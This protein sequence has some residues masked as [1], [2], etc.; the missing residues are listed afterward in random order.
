[1]IDII[2]PHGGISL[3]DN[4]LS[5]E[6]LIG[7]SK[8]ASNYLKIHISPRETRD[9][10][11]L[12]IGA[13]SPLDGFAGYEDWKS[14]CND[15]KLA[16]K[17]NVLWPIPITLSVS[18]NLADRIKIGEEIAL[19]SDEF[20]ET[21][22]TMKVE[23]KYPV[24]KEFE[25]KHVYKTT[26]IEHPGVKSVM[27][28]GEINLAGRIKLL[29]E[30]VYSLEFPELYQ[31]PA[32]SRRKFEELGWK[33]IAAF[34]VRNPMHRSH[35]HIVKIALEFVDGLYIHQ[36]TGK[37]KPGEIPTDVRIRCINALIKNYFVKDSVIQGG[38]PLDMRYAGPR[39]AIL[40]A[41]MRQNY[42]CSHFVIG[43]DY[44]GFGNYYGPF[45]SQD[46]FDELWDG[47][48][49][50][51]PLKIDWTFWCYECGNMASM[52]TCP[53][54]KESKLLL[55]GTLLRKKL[56]EGMNIPG[57]YSRKEVID[58]LSEYYSGMELPP[59]EPELLPEN[60]WNIW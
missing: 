31:N 8:K 35:E 12:G 10:I 13:F 55:S 24:N 30:G 46:I 40:H 51:Q 57:E 56:T 43:R 16:G 11:M 18:K 45:E 17:N 3:V 49:D 52:K 4:L 50:C 23:E 48:L 25:C 60:D 9:L 22:A 5:G 29:S 54:S 34:Q 36:L 42:G 26:D 38:Y 41:I 28:Q 58:I 7:E 44:A 53:H 14:I 27:S 39:E 19:F 21:M 32:D 33:T 2:K 59:D 6:E 20:N 15:M 1:M 37:E 47:A